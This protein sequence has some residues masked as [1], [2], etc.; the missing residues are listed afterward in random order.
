MNKICR[1]T[2]LALSTLVLIN[3]L[4]ANAKTIEWECDYKKYASKESGLKKAKDFSMTF[5]LDSIDDTAFI[6]GNIGV[7][8]VIPII[9]SQG[10]ITFIE[11]T[12]TK[13]VMTTTIIP[14]GESVHSRNS[15]L[16]NKLI[17]SQYY[18]NCT[19]L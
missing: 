16:P 3:S 14:N 2:V 15:T 5:I 17:A 1:G 13:N 6:K 10:S 4:P 9:G 7:S 11:I 8:K 12:D 19:K 18:G